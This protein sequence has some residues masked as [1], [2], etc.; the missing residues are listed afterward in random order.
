MK[1]RKI[2]LEEVNEDKGKF[3]MSA[4]TIIMSGTLFV[5]FLYAV[6]YSR[7][8]VNFSIDAIVGTISLVFLL[9]NLKMKY[10]IIKKYEEILDFYKFIDLS[11]FLICIFIKIMVNLPFDFSL[12]ILLLAYYISKI[13]INKTID[14]LVKH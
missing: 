7:F 13:K 14:R 3:L 12:I 2:S 9:R 5:Y 1:K 8:I 6:I 10:S 4:L 11:S